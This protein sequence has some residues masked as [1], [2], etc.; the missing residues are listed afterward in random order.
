VV[1][2]GAQVFENPSE[3]FLY[4]GYEGQDKEGKEMVKSELAEIVR[5]IFIQ[6]YN[7]RIVKE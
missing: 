5:G 3:G 6:V 7:W 1:A 4:V 2:V